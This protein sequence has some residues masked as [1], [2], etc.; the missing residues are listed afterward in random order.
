MTTIVEKERKVTVT[1]NYDVVILGGGL[2]GAA[3]AIAAARQ[4]AKTLLVEEQYILGGLATSGLIAYY[5]PLCDG[6]GTQLSFGLAEELL[7][8]SISQGEDGH[9]PTAWLDGEDIKERKKVR[10][11]TQFNPQLFALLLD[12]EI[13]KA[14]GEILFG[15]RLSDCVLSAENNEIEAVILE[16]RSGRFA[17]KAK[18]FIDATGDAALCLMAG[19]ETALYQKKNEIAAWYY[20][21][22]GGKYVLKEIGCRDTDEAYEVIGRFQGVDGKELSDVTVQ[23]HKITLER[24]L[25]GGKNGKEHALATLPTIPQ[26]RMTRKLVGKGSM[27]L[28]DDH[29]PAKDSVGMFG[30]WRKKGP[31]FEM[32]FATLIGKKIRNLGV[33]GRCISADDDAWDLTR[34]IPPCILSGEAIGTAAAIGG[35]VAETDVSKL[36]EILIKNGVKLHLNEVGIAYSK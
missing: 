17:V 7:K 4:G 1:G 5:L 15:T 31:A 14:G 25:E 21:A 13:T 28:D 30:N 19:E 9:Y 10:Y 27:R 26:V 36:Q 11:L 2:A 6:E 12:G 16:N 34:V 32:P 23:T 35:F 8:L 24:F 22:V 20:E 18:N 3:A 33:A 29:K